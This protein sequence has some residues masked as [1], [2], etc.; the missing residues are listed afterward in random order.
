MILNDIFI[1]TLHIFFTDLVMRYVEIVKHINYYFIVIIQL[2]SRMKYVPCNL[3]LF[4]TKN[5]LL[6]IKGDKFM[7]QHISPSEILIKAT[8]KLL[9]SY[10][11][12]VIMNNEISVIRSTFPTAVL[13]MLAG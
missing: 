1:M 10:F 11:T 12:C 13:D 3:F 9:L 6:A 4:E 5:C 8:A 2:T 7:K